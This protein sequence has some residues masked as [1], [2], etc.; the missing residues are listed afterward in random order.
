MKVTL[1]SGGVGGARLARGL[2]ALDWVDLSVI[3]NV[4]D[5]QETHGLYVSPD[6]DTVTYALAGIAGPHG[7]GRADDTFSFNKELGRFGVDNSF[8]LGDRD[9]ALKLYRTERL[10]SGDK[11]SEVTEVARRT[12]GIKATI[13]PATDDRLRTMVKIPD[14]WVTFQDYFVTRGHS[15]DVLELD[16]QGAPNASAAPG[17]IEDLAQ[18]DLVVIAPSNPPLSIFPILAVPEI[19]EVVKEHPS[20]AAVSP[21]IGGKALRGPADAVM[22]TLG[23]PPGNVGVAEA[24]RGLIGRLVIDRSDGHDA[25]A[26][27][28]LEVQVTDTVIPEL[29]SAARLARDILDK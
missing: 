3:V 14:G 21:L 17:V 23:Y 24:Y 1:L 6:L 29:E 16:Y 13:H 7:W 20:V 19:G 12:F 8:K 26:L 22:A 25:E 27:T 9:L 18:A 28:G 5:D 2:D 4:G 10:S 11:L 15:D